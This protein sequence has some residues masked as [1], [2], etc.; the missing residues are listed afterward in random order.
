VINRMND[1]IRKLLPLSWLLAVM[2]CSYVYGLTNGISRPLHTMELWLDR[3]IPFNEYFVIPYIVWGPCIFLS[4][5]IFFFRNRDAYYRMIICSVMGHIVSYA[6]Y[7]TYQTHVPRPFIT[8]DSIF[9]KLVNYIYSNDEP[10]NCFPSIHVFTTYLMMRAFYW[11]K[12]H[13]AVA[14][15]PQFIGVSIIL[16]TVFIKQHVVIDV[17]GGIILAE[18]LLLLVYHPAFKKLFLPARSSQPARSRQMSA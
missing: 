9:L 12:L 2:A 1:Q 16:S 5:I 15:I 11:E 17:A 8:D 10:V 18:T 14:W 7:M 4:F 6:F 13:K 3:I